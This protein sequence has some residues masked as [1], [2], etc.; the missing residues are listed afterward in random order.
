MGQDKPLED[1]P[2]GN[3]LNEIKNLNI[4]RSKCRAQKL[5]SK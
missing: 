5:Q 4:R 2:L 3:V 1:L